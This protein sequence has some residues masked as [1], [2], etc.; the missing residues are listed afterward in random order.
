MIVP[1]FFED[2]A[3]RVHIWCLNQVLI[4]MAVRNIVRASLDH[5][6][7]LREEVNLSFVVVDEEGDYVVSAYQ[8]EQLRLFVCG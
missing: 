4:S 1:H 2:I 6:E 7:I 3:E 8:T 5:R